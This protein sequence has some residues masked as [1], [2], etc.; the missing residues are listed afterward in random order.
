MNKKKVAK[1]IVK[2]MPTKQLR[3]IL[4]LYIVR[5]SR[6]IVEKYIKIINSAKERRNSRRRW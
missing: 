5:K 2:R 4:S 6:I 1:E 3:L